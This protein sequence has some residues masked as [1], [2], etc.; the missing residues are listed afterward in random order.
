MKILG[1][2]EDKKKLLLIG[3]AVLI[4]I[5]FIIV[6]SFILKS[7]DGD[8]DK[9]TT[10]YSETSSEIITSSEQTTIIETENTESTEE[11]TTEEVI[12]PSLMDI[13]TE[14]PLETTTPETTKKQPAT[15]KPQTTVKQD[16]TVNIT[17]TQGTIEY[18]TDRDG[19]KY[20]THIIETH[21]VDKNWDE[22]TTAGDYSG[23]EEATDDN[24]PD[25]FEEIDVPVYRE[26][27]IDEIKYKTTYVKNWIN[28][29][30]TSPNVDSYD[31][32]LL[33]AIIRYMETHDASI[34]DFI[35]VDDMNGDDWREV[36]A[37][38][39]YGIGLYK[40]FDWNSYTQ[41]SNIYKN[42][43]W[44]TVYNDDF[45]SITDI[46]FLAVPEKYED[47]VFQDYD[48]FLT[49]YSLKISFK[50]GGAN[51]IAWFDGNFSILDVDRL[52]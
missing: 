5:I 15:T 47:R 52:D 23:Y 3:L 37:A 49:H 19:E 30:L 32:F 42:L 43:L 2:K 25:V 10:S 41:Y 22:E 46:Q 1:E 4:T 45:S 6:L 20:T 16:T 44:D 18:E 14:V 9:K 48:G 13:T 12:A 33:D 8:E 11:T 51:Y 24:I 29:S 34:F 40:T 38:E 21:P 7:N 50:S 36:L 39:L 17:T 31:K 26:Q 28:N 35:Q 27:L